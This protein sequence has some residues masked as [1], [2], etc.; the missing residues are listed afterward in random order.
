MGCTKKK[1]F[2]C[3]GTV[4]TNA[5]INNNCVSFMYSLDNLTCSI[6]IVLIL[7]SL[8]NQ[9]IHVNISQVAV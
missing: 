5:E 1:H 9:A 4:I 6:S 8:I 7:L 3:K 2:S